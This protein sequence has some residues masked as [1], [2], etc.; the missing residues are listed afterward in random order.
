VIENQQRE[1][2]KEKKEK[3]DGR[4]RY[5]W[6]KKRQNCEQLADIDTWTQS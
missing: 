4:V 6:R 2:E 5:S 3:K 1:S